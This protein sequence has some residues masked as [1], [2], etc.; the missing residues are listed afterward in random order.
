MCLGGC[1]HRK[2]TP[3]LL[4]KWINCQLTCY[5]SFCALP[6]K[7]KEKGKKR[8][9]RK[10]KEK[11][12]KKEER[13]EGKKGKRKT[14]RKKRGGLKKQKKRNQLDGFGTAYVP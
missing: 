1:N 14:V 11:E 2:E 9:K 4:A 12:N 10:K 3:I 8:K 13:R 6:A 5:R 7:K